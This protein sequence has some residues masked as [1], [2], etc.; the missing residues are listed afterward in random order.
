MRWLVGVLAVV[1]ALVLIGDAL[2]TGVVERRASERLTQELQGPA[3]V[4]LSGWP[5]VVRLLTSSVP[6]AVVR[7][8]DVPLTGTNAT[9]SRLEARVTDVRVTGG[10]LLLGNGNFSASLDE[11]A[12][13]RL[14]GLPEQFTLVG[15]R[16]RDGVASVELGQ[17]PVIRVT[18]EVV[19]GTVVLRPTDPLFSSLGFPVELQ[20]LP[21]GVRLTSVR[22][23]RNRLD[24]TGRLE[25]GALGEFPLFAR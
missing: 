17:L 2:L 13:T 23:R 15:V 7:A 1:V 20:G 19:N 22:V 11:G 18:A 24:I 9:L 8:T 3:Q 16:L 25:S 14:L 4:E 21:A 10:E 6:V 5:V 12:V